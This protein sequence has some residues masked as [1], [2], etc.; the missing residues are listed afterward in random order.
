[1]STTGQND[2]CIICLQYHT[3]TTIEHIVPH[4][5][6]NDHYILQKGLVC[7]NCNNRFAKYEHQVVS[8]APFLAIRRKY[9]VAPIAEVVPT[10][11]TQKNLGFFLAKILY[12]S[13]Y[14]SKRSLLDRYD[15]E[16]IRETLAGKKDITKVTMVLYQGKIERSIHIPNI[17]HRWRLRSIGIQLKYKE[18]DGGLIFSFIYERISFVLEIK[19]AAL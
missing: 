13:I 15:L 8:S 19:K 5:L 4:S 17:I 6:G 14:R 2:R 1:M 7:R 9:G 16:P 3:E 12:E 18:Q 10:I 11:L